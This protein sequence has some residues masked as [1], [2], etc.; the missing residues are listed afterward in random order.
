[1]VNNLKSLIIQQIKQVYGDVKVYDEP[2]R[3]GLVTP[4]FLV[5]IFNNS[6]ETQP[7]RNVLRAVSINVTYFPSTKDIRSE[8]DSVF[9]TFQDEFRYVS[10]KYRVDDLEGSVEDDVLV[11]TFTVNVRLREIFEETKMQILGGV[12]ID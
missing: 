1:L 4:A 5:L 2:V 11:I 9:E 3:Q 6:Q 8:C 12:N 7:A 10:N